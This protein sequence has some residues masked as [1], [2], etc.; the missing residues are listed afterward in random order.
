[1]AYPTTGVFPSGV[2]GRSTADHRVPV[3][4]DRFTIDPTSGQ[5]PVTVSS[6]RDI[7]LPQVG[8]GLGIGLA[9]AFGVYPARRSTR[10]RPLAH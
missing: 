6:G 9:L 4:D 2:P 7:E 10:G 3:V 8:I 1:M 5:D